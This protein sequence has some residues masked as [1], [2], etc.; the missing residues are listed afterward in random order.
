LVRPRKEFGPPGPGPDGTAPATPSRARPAGVVALGGVLAFVF[1]GTFGAGL[2]ETLGIDVVSDPYGTPVAQPPVWGRIEAERLF[3]R[4]DE[5]VDG[6]CRGS[7]KLPLGSTPSGSGVVAVTVEG[8]RVAMEIAFVSPAIIVPLATAVG[9][10]AAHYGGRVDRL[11]MRLVDVI[12]VIPAVLLVLIFQ[13]T[14]E[15]GILTTVVVFGLLEWG[16]VARLVRSEAP[17]R[18]GEAYV[19]AARSAG[20]SDLAIV[21]RHV[22]PN[23]SSTVVTAV[24][25]LMPKLIVIEASVAF[26]GFSAPFSRSWGTTISE[27]VAAFPVVWWASVVPAA[28]LMLTAASL[29]V[30]GDA[31]RDVLDPRMG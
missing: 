14:D 31:L 12:Q 24:T 4:L 5:V 18:A 2:V 1:V 9:T 30:L 10:V 17:Q 28:A 6:Q 16:S 29:H 27:G 19:A 3:A 25:T 11:L 23:V 13:R 21:R 26:P 7:W 15:R 22:V 20:A 8:A